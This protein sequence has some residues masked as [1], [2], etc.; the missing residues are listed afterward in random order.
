MPAARDRQGAGSAGSYFSTAQHKA[1]EDALRALAA[2]ELRLSQ[3][4]APLTEASDFSSYLNAIAEARHASSAS[5]RTATTTAVCDRVHSAVSAANASVTVALRSA[6][7]KL[8]ARVSLV[9]SS[10][11]TVDA[12]R[13]A[14][15]RAAA[16]LRLAMARDA[17]AWLVPGVDEVGSTL[18]AIAKWETTVARAITSAESQAAG[19]RSVVDQVS[20]RATNVS[21]SCRAAAT[22]E[23]HNAV[24]R[25]QARRAAP[26]RGVAAPTAASPAVT[27]RGVISRSASPRTSPS[28]EPATLS[29]SPEPATLSPSPE[30]TTLSPSPEPTTLSPSPEPTTGSPSPEPTTGSPSPEPT[31]ESPSP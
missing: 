6:L 18:A 26:T 13:R 21:R 17:Q 15:E 12:D 29:P 24:R 8:H 27:P 5:T 3:D 22:R 9:R 19:Y 7:G 10:M 16:A 28:P 30:P 2:A 25:A 23:Q 11:A 4:F 14:V 1:V 20:V 31:T